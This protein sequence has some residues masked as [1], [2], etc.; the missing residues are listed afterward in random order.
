MTTLSM[1]VKE[2]PPLA[3]LLWTTMEVNQTS[4]AQDKKRTALS[5]SRWEREGGREREGGGREREGGR[6]LTWR[7]AADVDTMGAPD[8]LN[9]RLRK[10]K[11]GWDRSG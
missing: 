6:Q 10:D 1:V 2:T 8:G 9:L 11:K 5:L 7:E 3:I 4:S